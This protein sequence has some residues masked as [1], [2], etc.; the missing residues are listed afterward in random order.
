MRVTSHPSHD[1]SKK[2]STTTYFG[3]PSVNADTADLVNVFNKSRT[4]CDNVPSPSN[5]KPTLVQLEWLP[6]D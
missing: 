2:L 6:F 3:W 1:S 5:R 4:L